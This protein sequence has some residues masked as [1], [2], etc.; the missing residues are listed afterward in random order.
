LA[1]DQDHQRFIADVTHWQLIIAAILRSQDRYRVFIWGRP[2][3]FLSSD[4]GFF[5]ALPVLVVVA[6]VGAAALG[7]AGSLVP[8]LPESQPMVIAADS[9]RARNDASLLIVEASKVERGQLCVTTKLATPRNWGRI[10]R[11]TR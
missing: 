9:V 7:L 3:G 6:A 11:S 2:I 8:V 5:G 1:S 4:I 10:S